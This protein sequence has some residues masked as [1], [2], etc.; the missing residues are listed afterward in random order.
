MKEEI[1][2]DDLGE[3]YSIEIAGSVEVHNRTTGAATAIETLNSAPQPA[4]KRKK[5]TKVVFSKTTLSKSK[6]VGRDGIF[7]FSLI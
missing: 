3:Q 5:T 7:Q 4:P 2:E 6:Y 1:D